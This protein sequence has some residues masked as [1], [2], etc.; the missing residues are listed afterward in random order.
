MRGVFQY[1]VFLS[2]NSKSGA[3]IRLVPELMQKDGLNIR[4]DEEGNFCSVGLRR[5]DARRPQGAIAAAKI[6][7]GLECCAS[8]YAA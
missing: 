8:S 4:L 1:H 6:E 5:I 3:P 2:D 7:E